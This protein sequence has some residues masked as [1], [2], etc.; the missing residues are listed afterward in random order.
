MGIKDT[1]AFSL[2]NY[3]EQRQADPFIMVEIGH[4]PRPVA[5]N[6]VA[7]TGQRAYIGVEGWLRDS[8]GDRRKALRRMHE[9]FIDQ[10]IFYIQQILGEVANHDSEL[11]Y[12]GDY[13]PVTILPAKAANEVFLSN[14]FGDPKVASMEGHTEALAEEMSRLMAEN[15]RAVVRETLTPQKVKLD[16]EIL[17]S[18]G[19]KALKKVTYEKPLFGEL[20]KLYATSNDSQLYMTRTRPFYLFIGRHD[21]D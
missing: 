9:P 4:G 7:F 16:D 17:A 2:E 3:L 14:V 12:A 13:D 5:Y 11:I 20:E 18:V 19:L 8:L 6:Q 1:A 21:T 15:G 10:N